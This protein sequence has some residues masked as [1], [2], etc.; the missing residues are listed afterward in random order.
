[1][2]ELIDRLIDLVFVEDIGDGDYIIFF[3]IF[4]IVMGKLKFLIKEVGVLV[5]IEIVKE[6]FYCFDLMM[7]VEVFINDGVEVKLGDV[8]MIVEGKI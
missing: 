7:K 3:C 5:G 6:I 1:M 4:V 8:V 2:N